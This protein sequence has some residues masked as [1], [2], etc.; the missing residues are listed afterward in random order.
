[1]SLFGSPAPQWNDVGS[2]V[3]SKTKRLVPFLDASGF[4][5]LLDPGAIPSGAFKDDPGGSGFT[6]VDTTTII[7][8]KPTLL[9]S[10]AV[11]I[12]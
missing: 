2:I 10:A 7:G 1:M 12:Y 9:P 6:I 4:W 3:A 11:V 5:V 8:L